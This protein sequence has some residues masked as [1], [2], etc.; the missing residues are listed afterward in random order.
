M[1]D[2]NTIVQQEFTRQASAYAANPSISDQGRIV[3]L[4]H[5]VNPTPEHR[6]LEV[7]T[8][9]GYVAMTLATLTG[10]VVGVDLTEALLVMAERQ[11]QAQGL[12]NLCFQIADAQQ[13]PFGEGEFDIVVCRFAF[14]HFENASYVLREMARVCCPQGAIAV[15]DLVVSEHPMRAAYQNHFEN[16][17]DPSHVA[18]FSLSKLLT[19]FAATGLEVEYVQTDRLTPTVE[20]WLANAQTPLD[21]AIEVR[22]LIEQDEMHDL[23][24]TRPFP[25]QDGQ[26]CFTQRTAIVVG[27]KLAL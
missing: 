18:A 11:R 27:R 21:R 2:H 9:P 7:A 1:K 3:R 25:S 23:S 6:V 22:Q 16:L 17:R 14:H 26:L 5:A 12:H 10:Q 20:C 15:E 8:G 4:V 19:I 13:L 24:G